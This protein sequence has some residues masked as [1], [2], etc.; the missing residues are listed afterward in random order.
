MMARFAA[1]GWG[2]SAGVSLIL[3]VGCTVTEPS[4]RML[5]YGV[6]PEAASLVG[7]AA[8]RD[9]IGSYTFWDGL[10]PMPVRGY[11]LV[12]GLGKN[13]STTCPPAVR[14]SLVQSMLKQQ[15][16]AGGRVDLTQIRPEQLIADPDT[17]VV[18]VRGEVPPGAVAGTRFDVG[19]VAVPGTQT[20]S[21]RGGRLFT[22]ELEVFRET[23]AGRS[24]SG[25][26]IGR[27]SG[28]LFVNPFADGDADSGIDPLQAVVILGGRT[29]AP[30][31]LRLVL[32]RPSYATAQRIQDRINSR[33]PGE[34][35]TANAVSPSYI[36]VRVP[37]EFHQ[38][39]AH[40]LGLVRALYLNS[41]PGF[42]AARARELGEEMLQPA[43][44][45]ALIALCLEGLG[46]AAAS[47]LRPLYAHD[48]DHVSFYGAAAG[49]RMG[50]HVAVDALARHAR[51][52]KSPFRFQAIR[53]LG[54]A[55]G[56]GNAAHELR[57]LLEEEDPRVQTEAY[58]ALVARSDPYVSSRRAGGDN[59]SLDLV[60][61][62]RPNMIYVKRN[63]SRRVALFG[64]GWKCT[65]PLYY[66]A[67]DGSFMLNAYPDDDAVTVLRVV[68][69]TDARSPPIRAPIDLPALIRLLGEDP[70]LDADGQI[71]GLGLDYGSVVAALHALARD[72]SVNAK[73]VVEQPNVAE[74]FGPG[75]PVGRPESELPAR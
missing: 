74:L 48:R 49:I 51:N 64:E 3:A 2:R 30:R 57:G 68:P 20:R 5:D 35:R 58:E 21:L 44:P 9:T 31:D 1:R 24:I 19:V 37:R 16:A 10:A 59:F 13:G 29:T 18:I 45:H 54:S 32:G 11:G 27:A 6:S 36:D 42:E 47:V 73:F 38:D 55:T 22:S 71:L 50:D 23:A 53:A 69:S 65:T 67:P 60:P 12:V 7:S 66:A 75:R 28:P 72:H 43:A 52:P 46:R 34:Q 14:D 62:R 25:K 61:T 8:F 63:Q 41:D 56:M 70:E 4:N 26:T 39:T 33:F 40:F 17:A 15:G